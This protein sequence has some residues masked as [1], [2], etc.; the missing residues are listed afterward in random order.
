MRVGSGSVMALFGC[1]AIAA[2]RQCTQAR[3]RR[4]A[5]GRPFHCRPGPACGPDTVHH[6]ARTSSE[7]R[8]QVRQAGDPRR[9]TMR[10]LD[11][12]LSVALTMGQCRQRFVRME[13]SGRCGRPPCDG[14]KRP[15][16]REPLGSRRALR[17][18][19]LDSEWTSYEFGGSAIAVI[20]PVGAL[21]RAAVAAVR[22][23]V[24]PRRRLIG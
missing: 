13:D 17:P 5:R 22:T 18:R 24:S 19:T 8:I 10:P 23:I 16:R 3:M 6:T 11:H 20:G 21:D 12:L 15:A 4:A 7:A 14:T 9:K 1:L 2:P